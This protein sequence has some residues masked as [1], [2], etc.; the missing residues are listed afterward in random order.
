MGVED[1][2]RAAMRASG[3][4]PKVIGEEAGVDYGAIYK[5]LGGRAELRSST[6]ARLCEWAQL[7]LTPKGGGTEARSPGDYKTALDEGIRD[8]ITRILT[9]G[10]DTH[11]RNLLRHH[12]PEGRDQT[13]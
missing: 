8:G 9:E 6:F 11:L 5:F 2:L 3:K 1:Q 7:E 12:L 10:F 4:P 13:P